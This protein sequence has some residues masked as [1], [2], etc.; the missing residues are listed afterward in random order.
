VKLVR[1]PFSGQATAQAFVAPAGGS[2][3][4]NI[5]PAVSALGDNGWLLQWTEGAAGA[6][7]VRLQRLNAKL[8]PVGDARLVSPKGANAG[9]GA[10]IAT[11]SHV[12]SVYIQ[13]TAGHDELWGASFECK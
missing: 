3:G 13:T 12:L 7:Q 11:G 5:A 4:G 2:G 10:V 1:V 8:E 6:Y 9:Q